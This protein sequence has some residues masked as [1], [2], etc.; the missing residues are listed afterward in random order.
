MPKVELYLNGKFFQTAE[1]GLIRSDPLLSFEINCTLRENMIN[2]QVD[3][4]KS[5]YY[6]QINKIQD[7]EIVVTFQ[8]KMN[9]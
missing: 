2:Y 6:K 1:I 5:L 3:K 4:F 7:F 9:D 8:S